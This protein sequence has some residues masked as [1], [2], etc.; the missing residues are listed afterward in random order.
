M[1]VTKNSPVVSLD[2]AELIPRPPEWQPSGVTAER[3]D[4]SRALLGETLGLKKLGCS[5][6][7]VAPG[8]A[9]YPFHS[10]R[11]ND[12]MF[13]LIAGRGELRLGDQRYPVAAGDVIGCPCGGPQTAHQLIN[14]G[15]EPLRYLAISTQ[16]DPE[17]CEYPDSGKVGAYSDGP[18]DTGLF[19]LSRQDTPVGYWDG[20]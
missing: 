18:A 7:Q 6:T 4:A 12:E 20:E 5:L 9:A 3:F 1:S 11:A 16:I 17:I 2:R 8:K 14:T 15:R 13:Y 19:H 10:H